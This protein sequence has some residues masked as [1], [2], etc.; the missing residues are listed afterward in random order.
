[1]HARDNQGMTALHWAAGK[2]RQDWIHV[3]VQRGASSEA[4]DA[5]GHSPMHLTARRDY[6]GIR[7]ELYKAT[8]TRSQGPVDLGTLR[9][10]HR[11]SPIFLLEDYEEAVGQYSTRTATV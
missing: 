7:R 4:R 2:G 5:N 10:R 1:M 9:L 3:F 11:Q 6:P 8:T